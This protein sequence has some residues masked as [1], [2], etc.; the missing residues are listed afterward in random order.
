MQSL[1]NPAPARRTPG[2]PLERPAAGLG[3]GLFPQSAV[4]A[5][6]P[7]AAPAQPVPAPAARPRYTA[8]ITRTA[9][10][11]PHVV[12]RDWGS[13]GY[14]SGYAAAQDNGCVIADH[15]LTVRGDRSRF[16]GAAGRVSVGFVEIANLES[17]FYH[18]IVGDV[19]ALRAALAGTSAAHRAMIAGFAAGYNRVLRMEPGRFAAACRGAAWLRPMTVDDVLLM[20]QAG[21]L[22]GASAPYARYIAAA[23]PPVPGAAPPGPAPSPGGAPVMPPSG[24]PGAAALPD[25]HGR[26]ARAAATGLPPRLRLPGPLPDAAGASNAWAFGAAATPNRRGL[27]A[28]A[29]HFPWSGHNRFRRIQLTIPG[30]MDVMGAALSYSPFVSIGY[31]RHVAW[32]HTVSTSQH[33]SL[34]ALALDPADP[35]RYRV[36]GAYESMTRRSITVAVKDAPPVTRTVYA[37]RFGMMIAIPGAGLGWGAARAYALRD[38]ELGNVRSGDTW[39]AL[40]RARDVTRVH[41]ALTRNLGIPYVNTIAADSRGSAFFSDTS[42]IPFLS[43]QRLSECVVAE[44]AT[45]GA[46]TATIYILDGT[47]NGCAWE[48][49]PAG[50]VPGL[51]PPARLPAMVRRDWVQNAN[52][53]YWLT[54]APEPMAALSPILGPHGKRQTL[55]TRASIGAIEGALAAGPVDMAAVRRL[56]LENRVLAAELTLNG[57]LAIRPGRPSL[58]RACEVLARWD[59]HADTG[60]RGAALFFAFWRKAAAIRDIWAVPF[61]PADPAN[62]PRMLNPVAG[63]AVLD[64]LQSAAADLAAAGIAIDAP[65]GQVQVSPRLGERIGI[66]G[67]PSAAGVLN[68]MHSAAGPEGVVPYHGTSYLLVVGWDRHGPVADSILAYSQSSDPESPWFADGTRDF[69]A[70]R[71]LRLP[72]TRAEVAAAR[73]APPATISE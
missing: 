58:A 14:G 28:A 54:H 2:R 12:A 25:S 26:T 42:A 35:T 18:R 8:T 69:S 20:V 39:L 13:L 60:S 53:S 3:P 56:S 52:D 16:F 71:W 47:R 11:L 40:A 4:P 59:R 48:V 37:T 21:A 34:Y 30:K 45:P 36:D 64:A 15:L 41:A 17:D 62:T 70:K 5:A 33:Q 10:G 29:P 49:D 63:D 66:H 31:N 57:L 50:P 6:L 22:Q 73:I 72:F 68:A 55:R 1:R 46:D 38:A 43:A 27:L 7:G 51:M 9:Q 24:E 61:D 32:T 19:D 65:L 67:G 44:G 23:A